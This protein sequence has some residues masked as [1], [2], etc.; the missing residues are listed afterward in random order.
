MKLSGSIY[1]L[2]NGQKLLG[3]YTFQADVNPLLPPQFRSAEYVA[4]VGYR[5]SGSNGSVHIFLLDDRCPPPDTVMKINKDFRSIGDSI[6]VR[7]LEDRYVGS[8][9]NDK[10]QRQMVRIPRK[11]DPTIMHL[12]QLQDIDLLFDTQIEVRADVPYQMQK[13][14]FELVDADIAYFAEGKAAI[15]FKGPHIEQV[16]RIIPRTK[17]GTIRPERVLTGGKQWFVPQ[18]IYEANID[19]G[20]G[21]FAAWVPGPNAH[22]DGKYFT[23][24]WAYQYGECRYPCYAS[25]K[26]K[27]PP[28]SVY[29]FDDKRTLTELMGACQ[30]NYDDDIPLGHPVR[31]LRYGKR[32]EPWTPWTEQNLIRTLELTVDTKTRGIL[33][34]KFMPFTEEFAKLLIKSDT[35]YMGSL[36]FD[37]LEGG[38]LMHGSSNQAR[39]ERLI[40]YAEAGARPVAYLMIVGDQA[41][42]ERELKI[43]EACD[44][45]R[46]INVQ[47][48]P[49]RFRRKDLTSEISGF[50]WD[51]LKGIGVRKDDLFRDMS[52]HGSYEIMHT[53]LVAARIHPFWLRLIGDNNGP[54][55]MCH[56][57]S[58]YIWCG[59]CFQ[60]TGVIAHNRNHT[61]ESEK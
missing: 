19:Y 2:P 12:D 42:T 28:K 15:K 38:P 61:K 46:K 40:K 43:L 1:H 56:H 6:V 27:C 16:S 13:D 7:E 10:N 57:N 3:I 55:R 11:K 26:H 21:C 22:F 17:L 49:L 32:T 14:I 48:L 25:G 52:S 24:W 58:Q 23:D 5:K 41:P 60:R 18:C 8:A 37:S 34:T 39:L 35:R 53:E 47:I 4:H 30:V 29:K 31:F 51:E 20:K 54:I 33:T 59:G 44:Y 50:S 9:N 36:G 45:G